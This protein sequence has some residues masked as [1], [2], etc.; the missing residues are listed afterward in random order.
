MINCR[1]LMCV[2]SFREMY[3]LVAGRIAVY[4]VMSCKFFIMHNLKV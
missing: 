4:C 2:N 1:I 3:V